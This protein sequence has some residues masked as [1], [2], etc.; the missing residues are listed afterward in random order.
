VAILSAL[1]SFLLRQI[2][3]I[4][5]AVFGWSITALF[6][7]LPQTKQTAISVALLLSVVWPIFLVGL[8]FPAAAAWVIAFLPLQKWMSATALR[9]LWCALAVITPAIVGLITHWVAPAKRGGK[10]NAILQGY[11]LALGYAVAFVITVVTVPIVKISSA[12][13][14]WTDQHVYV[15][16]RPNR[17]QAVLRELAEAFVSAGY[18]P[19]VADVPTS[20]AL[21]TKVMR[22]LARGAIAPMVEEEPKMLRS[23]DVELYLYPADMLLRGDKAKAAHVR[24]MMTRTTL[25]RDAY[26]VA[27]PRAQKLQDE[28]VGAWETMQESGAHG[29]EVL[30]RV[31]SEIDHADIP[32]EDWTMLENILR[33]AEQELERSR[34]RHEQEKETTMAT[35]KSTADL[36]REAAD[37]AKELVRIEVALAK[38]E[39]RKEVKEIEGAAAAFAVAAAALIVCLALLA[40]AIVLAVGATVPA[41]LIVAAC[42][43]VLAG[44]GAGVGYALIPKKPLEHTRERVGADVHQLEEHAA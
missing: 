30:A 31:R 19:E 17:Y 12:A 35:E 33:H 42:F 32:F 14:R 38:D 8:V 44:I 2:G 15:Q 37:E 11:P 40:V 7:K 21:S 28:I 29:R 20:M 23:K 1:L 22:A 13:K 18:V 4:L 36:V 16:P 26:L 10:L 41:A 6:G 3:K 24:A 39:A 25:E 9:V 34:Q 5:Q 43:F 27:T